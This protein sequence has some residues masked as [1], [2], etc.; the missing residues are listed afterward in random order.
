MDKLTLT[1]EPRSVT[2]KKVKHLRAQGQVP[3]SICGRGVTSENYVTDAKI[4]GK[5][6]Q[7]AGRSVLIELQTPSGNRQAF[8]RQIQRHPISNV[9]LH[10]DFRVVDMRVEMTAD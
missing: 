1:L 2:G 9:W 8:I 10:A 3:V 5:V 7:Q 4:F 6:Y